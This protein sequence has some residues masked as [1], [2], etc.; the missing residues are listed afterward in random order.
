MKRWMIFIVLILLFLGIVLFR[1]INSETDFT[2]A[3][4]DFRTWFWDYRIMDL[5]V[6]ILLIFGGA[7][8]IAAII[9][10]EDQN[11]D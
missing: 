4:E 5:A 6:Q 9:P 7:L 1:L 10:F 8:G 2:P 11:D 3:G